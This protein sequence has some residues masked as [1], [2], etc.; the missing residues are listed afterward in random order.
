MAVKFR[1]TRNPTAGR[2][3]RYRYALVRGKIVLTSSEGYPTA[4]HVFRA[5][6]G[7]WKG[8]MATVLQEKDKERSVGQPPAVPFTKDSLKPDDAPAAKAAKKA[9]KKTAKQTRGIGDWPERA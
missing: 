6:N 9:A 8:L 2:A 5:V 3:K 1:V 4:Q 7:L